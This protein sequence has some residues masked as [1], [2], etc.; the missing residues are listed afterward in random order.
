MK[1]FN[2]KILTV[3]LVVVAIGCGKKDDDSSSS[4]APSGMP[5]TLK[6]GC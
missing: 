1:V 5:S 2:S 3:G 4:S 6:V